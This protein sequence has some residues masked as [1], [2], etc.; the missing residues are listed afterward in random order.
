MITHIILKGTSR[1]TAKRSNSHSGTRKSVYLWEFLFGLLEDDECS[2]VIS[3]TNKREGI[4]TLHNPDELA[5]LWGTVK[6]R[7]NMHKYKLFR[8]MRNYYGKGMLRKV[9]HVF[10]LYIVSQSS[11]FMYYSREKSKEMAWKLLQYLPISMTV[12]FRNK[13]SNILGNLY[14]RIEKT[15][16]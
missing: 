4:F 10:F 14:N 13:A 5:K 12:L 2:S 1:P 16:G 7:P 9:T 15:S 3:W 6:N 8:A 11:S